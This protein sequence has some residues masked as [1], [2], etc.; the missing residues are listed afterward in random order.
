MYYFREYNGTAENR[1]YEGS[2][3]ERANDS[4]EELKTSLETSPHHPPGFLS[5]HDSKDHLTQAVHPRILTWEDGIPSTRQSDAA[6]NLRSMLSDKSQ[7]TSMPHVRPIHSGP[8]PSPEEAATL[9]KNQTVYM[10]HLESESRYVKEEMVVLRTKLSEVMEENRML[11]S[12]LKTAVVHEILKEGGD[13]VNIMGAFDPTFS[14]AFVATMGRHDFKRWQIELERLSKLHASKTDRLETHLQQSRLDVE[15]LEQ[16]VEDLKSQLRIQESIPTHENGQMGFLTETER[17][18]THRI[19]EK[20]TKERDDLIDHV[21]SLQAQLQKTRHSE[22]EAY[23]QM[24]KGIELVEQAQLEQTEALVQKE[25]TNDELQRV[26]QRFEDHVRESQILIRAERDAAR[27][28]SQA[29]VDDL[30]EKLKELGEHYTLVQSKYEKEVREKASIS[31]EMAELKSQLRHCDKEVTVTA[32]SYRTETTNASLQRNSA[33]Y[34][35]NRL[36]SELEKARHERDQEMSRT[37]IELDD[38]RQ[39]LNKAERELINSKEECIHMTANVQALE[40]ELHLAKMARDTIERTR[41]DDLRIIRKQAQDREE[42]MRMKMEE[43]DDRHNQSVHEMDTMLL[44]QNKLIMKLR[45][46][47]K[48]QAMNLEKTVKKYRV[49]NSKL[50][51]S[52][53]ELLKRMERMVSRSNELEVQAEHY[54]EVHQKMRDR[55]RE[56]DQKGQSQAVQLVEALTK[57]SQLSR[58]RQ[59]LAREVEFLRE[60]M[61]RANQ[62]SQITEP[63]KLNSS[64]SKALVDDI[65][66]SLTKDERD[67]TVGLIPQLQ[68]P[69]EA[70]NDDDPTEKASDESESEGSP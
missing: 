28:E 15:K 31:S 55:L 63:L 13:A 27:K 39:R 36:R 57:Y 11:H 43:A 30:N 47:C 67:G 52:N 22:E 23:Q 12:E 26:R 70:N 37:K 40:R 56:L 60:Q 14:E 7:N 29:L 24:K 16:T 6:A 35:S 9:L 68:I 18:T 1:G 2:I 32:E 51:H 20:L 19:I 64:P 4:L 5:G 69:S 38:L 3:R 44:K 48:K 42:E 10:S 62:R 54:T 49:E 53:E 65:L 41:A 61:L 33:L 58:D 46:E 59:L 25:Q 34:E 45:E 50:S 66:N 21:T 8:L 17:N